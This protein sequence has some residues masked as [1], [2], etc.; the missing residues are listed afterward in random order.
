YVAPP[1]GELRF[2]PPESVEPWIDTL[3]AT[4]FG[5]ACPQKITLGTQPPTAE[6]C[7]TLN[8]WAHD[9][10]KM[11]PVM[12][13]IYGGGYSQGASRLPLYEASGLA[14]SGD[15]VVVSM[16]YRL[17]ALGFLA[18]E[19][20]AEESGVD[21]AGNY[22]TRDQIAA[23]QWV[24]RNIEAFG[25]DPKQVTVFGES[26]G[27]TSVC[28]MLGSPMAQ[29]LYHRA[30]IQSGGGCYGIRNLRK[31]T[32]TTVSAIKLGQQF[33]IRA[34]CDTAD[35][36]LTC[37]RALDADETV[38]LLLA[39]GTGGFG[40]PDTGPNIDGIV[41]PTQPYVSVLNGSLGD[42][43]V[44]TGANADEMELFLIGQSFTKASY[45]TTVNTFFPN[46][47]AALLQLYPAVDDAAA[48]PAYVALV[49][50]FAFICP[51]LAFAKA[52]SGGKSTSYAYH[53]TQSLT[54]GQLAGLGAFHALEVAYV[55]GSFGGFGAT[56]TTA[57]LN[58]SGLMMGAWSSFAK[59]GSPAEPPGW[60]S[61]DQDAANIAIFA[62]PPS[63]AQQIREG[64]CAEL[65]K[66]G[67]VAGGG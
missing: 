16:N 31:E 61:Y 37:L 20:L 15:V 8:V 34:G 11:R 22:G 13:W 43:P 55:F 28:T 62:D 39:G 65:V 35:D 33:S 49:S 21:S 6:D 64:R 9:D 29:G 26:A 17:G 66:L 56:P 59:T 54:S 19:T 30:I 40:L 53:F 10:K 63:F 41:L 50:D 27:G 38:E 44:I 51:S 36:E 52:A 46:N 14:T 1:I 4:R 18:T 60:A 67:L 58:V 32:P 25:G 57:D 42:V 12:V 7:L 5:D 2:R 45:E 23:L 47:A 3:D 24:K 48:K